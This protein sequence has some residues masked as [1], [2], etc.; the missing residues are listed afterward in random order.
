MLEMEAKNLVEMTAK[1]LE[2]FKA[3]NAQVNHLGWKYIPSE[4]RSGP[5]LSYATLYPVS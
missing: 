4:T 5:I 2:R 1:K 3:H